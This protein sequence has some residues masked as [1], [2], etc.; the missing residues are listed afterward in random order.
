MP[1]LPN[2]ETAGF[3]FGLVKNQW[4][5]AGPNNT[6]VDMNIPSVIKAIELYEIKNV[7]STLLKVLTAGRAWIDIVRSKSKR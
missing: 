7:H 6:P 2:N 1:L 3:I 5:T 4:I